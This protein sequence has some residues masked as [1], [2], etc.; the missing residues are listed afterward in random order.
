M[1]GSSLFEVAMKHYI[2][3][4]FIP[5]YG[6]VHDCVFCNQ[7]KITGVSTSVTPDDVTT[8]LATHL[9]GINQER[10]IEAAFY[11]GSFTALPL[12]LQA[13][14]LAPAQNLLRQKRIQSIRLSTRPDCINKMI[15]QQLKSY[16]VTTIELGAQSFADDVLY[17]AQRGHTA[18]TIWQAAMQIRSAGFNLGLQLMLGLP[19]EEWFD[20][21]ESLEQV[22]RIK[23]DFV[24]IYP[25]LVLKDTILAEQYKNGSYR[26][27]PLAEAINYSALLKSNFIA[28]GIPVI[29][30]GLQATEALADPA[31]VLA[32]P[33]HPAFGEMVDSRIFYLTICR[34][35]DSL[36]YISGQTVTLHYHPKDTSKLRGNRN[37][38]VK[39][40]QDRYKF[41]QF[42]YQ[43]DGTAV[44][45]VEVEYDQQRYFISINQGIDC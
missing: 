18:Q 20:I 30:T 15:L 29:R 13:Q 35:L 32:G 24:R 45:T 4:I 33:Y 39:L 37:S 17:Q 31:I 26:P 3:P 11:G 5:H 14:F 25:T 21:V 7:R 22:V 10:Y 44:S 38:N 9:A 8:I 12:G 40:W 36:P 1:T 23:P 34:L 6:C 28:Q 41:Q 27:L 42:N 16:G 2:I 19:G 43:A